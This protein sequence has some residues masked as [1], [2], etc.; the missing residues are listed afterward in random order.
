M[1]KTAMWKSIMSNESSSNLASQNFDDGDHRGS[2]KNRRNRGGKSQKLLRHVSEEQDDG[3]G[4]LKKGEES[5]FVGDERTT[6]CNGDGIGNEAADTDYDE[7]FGAISFEVVSFRSSRGY[8][9]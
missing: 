5:H 8:N 1:S 3:H 2:S 4:P 9:R 7:D 6:L